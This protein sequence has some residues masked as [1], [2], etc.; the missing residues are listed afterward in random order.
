MK[1]LQGQYWATASRLAGCNVGAMVSGI[2][3]SSFTGKL[4]LVQMTAMGT[5]IGIRVR[6]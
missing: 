3:T 1:R 6:Q 5:L 2:S 4:D